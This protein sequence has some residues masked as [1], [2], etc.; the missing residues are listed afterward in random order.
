MTAPDSDEPLAN[1]QPEVQ[2]AAEVAEDAD[3]DADAGAAESAPSATEPPVSGASVDGLLRRFLSL[4]PIRVSAPPPPDPLVN[5][6]ASTLPAPG[7]APSLE[8]F[9]Q[10]LAEVEPLLAA[11]NWD[12]VI[13]ALSQRDTLPPPLA[14]LY[15]VA[16]NERGG[17]GDPHGLAIRAAAALLCVPDTSE[18][19]LVVAKRLL[20]TNPIAWQKRSA[21]SAGLS[22]FIVLTVA[23]VGALVGFLVGPGGWIL[24]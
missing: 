22:I 19:A 5:R 23:T 12:A 20:R 1:L 2:P 11:G 14:L 17:K 15:A 10:D 9:T 7:E 6:T 3:A 13:E 4:P 16:L 24:R 21:P 18:T 8:T